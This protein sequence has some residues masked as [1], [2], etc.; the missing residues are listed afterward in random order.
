[1]GHW[2]FYGTTLLTSFFAT[3]ASVEEEL[4]K[5]LSLHWISWKYIKIGDVTLT[6]NWHQKSHQKKVEH[7]HT[8]NTE[9]NQRYENN[10]DCDNIEA[11]VMDFLG[12]LKKMGE[13]KFFWV[14]K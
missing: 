9:Q 5:G 7:H 12:N 1:M 3:L 4:L 10:S 14:Y 8:W 2:F 6:H 11:I 13:S